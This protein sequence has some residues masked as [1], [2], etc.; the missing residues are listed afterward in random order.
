[1][2][3]HTRSPRETG[4]GHPCGRRAAKRATDPVTISARAVARTSPR[5]ALDL[6]RGTRGHPNG[7]PPSRT[8]ICCQ[9]DPI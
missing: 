6:R 7:V 9:S 2:K 3:T 1:M 4:L 8:G 5:K